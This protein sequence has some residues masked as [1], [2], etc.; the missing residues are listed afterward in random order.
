MVMDVDL[1]SRKAKIENEV[2]ESEVGIDDG[3]GTRLATAAW[4]GREWKW[5]FQVRKRKGRC[6]GETL[7]GRP[8]LVWEWR[9]ATFQ[10]A[11]GSVR[12]KMAWAS[13]PRCAYNHQV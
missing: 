9:K 7:A 5:E 3:E 1:T 8:V 2:R 6:E 10:R 13:S 11:L 4:R 12:A